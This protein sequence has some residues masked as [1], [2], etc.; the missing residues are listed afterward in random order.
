[1]TE[2]KEAL[3]DFYQQVGERYQEED[4]VYQTL[5]GRLRKRF[6]MNVIV[7]WRG[8]LFDLGCNRGMYL[9]AYKGGER[10]GVDLSLPVLQKIEKRTELHLAMADAENLD[11]FAENSFEHVLC[12]E[13]LEH[14]LNPEK[15]FASI[16][17]VLKPGGTAL[18]TTPNYRGQKPKWIDLGPLQEYGIGCDCEKGCFHTAY[19]PDELRALSEQAGLQA[20]KTG[21]LEKQI[22]YAAKIPAAIL[23]SGRAMNRI[24]RSQRF[25]RWN[26]RFVHTGT[27][28]CYKL[29]QKLGLENWLTGKIKEGVRSYI[30]V[31]KT[32]S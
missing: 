31:T 10:F 17:R 9:H 32:E 5:R 4:L 20:I 13:V 7:D 21:T 18:I 16:A 1:M 23:L 2:P 8:S 12:S 30:L 3:Y 24:F 6:V 29:S 28:W 26:E 19:R 22:K 14:C 25:E 15:V 11:C 27:L